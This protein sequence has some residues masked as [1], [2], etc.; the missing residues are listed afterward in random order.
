MDFKMGWSLVWGCL[1][2][3]QG[4]QYLREG[5]GQGALSIQYCSFLIHYP[6]LVELNLEHNASK[7]PLQIVRAQYEILKTLKNEWCQWNFKT[8]PF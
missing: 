7:Y 1:P 4:L 5:A 8:V 2:N 3:D 6:Y